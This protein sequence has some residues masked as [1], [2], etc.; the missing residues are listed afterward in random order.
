MTVLDPKVFTLS[1]PAISALVAMLIVLFD[2]L[3]EGGDQ[4]RL[5]LKLALYFGAT[6]L[7]T[8]SA[9]IYFYFPELFL[10][11]NG[12]YMFS[13]ISM[14][15]FL[16]AFIFKI[17]STDKPE[18]FSYLHYAAPTTLAIFLIIVSLFTPI[19]EQMLTIKGNG[20]Y[21]GGSRLFF[22][23]SNGKML[24]RLMFSILYIVLIFKR[25]P[26]YRK[27]IV[28]YSSDESKSSLQWVPIYLFF[29]LGTIPIPLLGQFVPR[30]I[31]VTS[32]LAFLQVL[33]LIIQHSFLAFHA[34]KGHYVL[35]ENVHPEGSQVL[36]YECSPSAD[37]SNEQANNINTNN[38][39]EK[40][41]NQ[42]SVEKSPKVSVKKE[43]LT[44]ELFECYIRTKRPYLN[45]E[46]KIID[47]V[48]DLNINRT[49]ISTFIN[50]EYGL[51]FSG[52]IN[53]QRLKEYERL[54][55]RPALQQ[56]NNTEIAEMAG[57]GSYRNYMRCMKQAE[58]GTQ[59]L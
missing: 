21:N 23:A 40:Q 27:Y 39:D 15:I 17:T 14:P 20:A 6:V 13:F 25:L 12:L 9:F 52:Y 3:E 16:Y 38:K 4:R 22:Y 2:I 24:I 34:I 41:D 7:T 56:K 18:R 5:K 29:M 50:A 11:L 33:L 8:S 36:P 53:Q 1:A 26:R 42:G 46:L 10:W 57:F 47:L 45:P 59:F 31:L 32:G 54:R 43:L 48:N 28:H 37:E 49:Y 58:I 35:Y 19:E 51:S 30:D 55:S 44:R